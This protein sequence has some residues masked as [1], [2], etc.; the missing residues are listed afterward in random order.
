MESVVLTIDLERGD[1]MHGDGHEL[2]TRSRPDV[3]RSVV[4][5]V[6]QR[7]HVRNPVQSLYRE[8]AE[9]PGLD[10]RPALGS[11]KMLDPARSAARL[12]VAPVSWDAVSEGRM[13]SVEVFMASPPLVHSIAQRAAGG[14]VGPKVPAQPAVVGDC[15]DVEPHVPSEDRNRP[16]RHH[17]GARE[18]ECT[19]AGPGTLVTKPATKCWWR[20]T[21]S[22][23]RAPE[24]PAHELER[25][26]PPCLHLVQA[27]LCGDEPQTLVRVSAGQSAVARA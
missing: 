2:R 6:V 5:R 4:N 19:P 13:P 15:R 1:G 25:A 20:A 22:M 24:G 23:M 9:G 7:E 16:D 8:T 11:R 21:R 17:R 18:A 26:L 3:D 12:P 10:Q 14:P 27:G